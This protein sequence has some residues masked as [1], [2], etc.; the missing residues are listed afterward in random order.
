MVTESFNKVAKLFSC[1]CCDYVT[2][3]KSSFDKHLLTVKHIKNQAIKKD[4][5][6]R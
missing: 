2:C 4:A 3:K 6:V 1:S 5:D